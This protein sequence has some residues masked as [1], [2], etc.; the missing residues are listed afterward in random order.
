MA[1]PVATATLSDRNRNKEA[2]NPLKQIE[3]YNITTAT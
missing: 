1:T 2:L 3:G